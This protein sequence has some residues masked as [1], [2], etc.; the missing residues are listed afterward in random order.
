MMDIHILSLFPGMFD[1]PLSISMVK[2]AQDAGILKIHI[3]NIRDFAHD[4][5][6]MVDDAPF[7]GGPGMVMKPEPI[8]EAVEAIVPPNNF[9]PTKRTESTPVILLSPHGRPF[10]QTIA[11][12]LAT[13]PKIILICGHYEGVDGRVGTQL[14]TD[15]ISLGDYV[16]TGG[17]LPAMVLVDA[18]S[19]LIPG[20]LGHPESPQGDSFSIGLLQ[21]PQYTRPSRFRDMDVPDIL[22]S[23]NHEAIT[24]WKRESA[25][26]QT[27]LWR[28][29]LLNGIPLTETDK[30][31]LSDIHSHRPDNNADR[32]NQKPGHYV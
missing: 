13:E 30:K 3:R 2:R 15:C 5:H 27:L 24:T 31:Y 19:R 29:D 10:T 6:R 9:D 16:L 7:G 1:G 25:L 32:P 21:G 8:F 17:E 11:K 12:Q 4:R 26:E 20:V 28:P 18:I 23:G 22:L 14:A